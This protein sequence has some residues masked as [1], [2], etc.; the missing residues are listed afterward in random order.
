MI[1]ALAVLGKASMRVVTWLG[2]VVAA[3]AL[4]GCAG[5]T[6]IVQQWQDPAYAGG[7]F[8]RMFVIGVT[9]G[10]TVRRVFEDAFCAQLKARGV[11]CVQSY[12]L[13]PE[14][15]LAPRARYDEA[16]RAARADSV[17]IAGVLRVER[18]TEVVPASP[19][20]FGG[21]YSFYGAAW[22]GPLFMGYAAPPTV[23]QFDQ[24]FVESRLFSVASD[25]PVW[26]AAS[27]VFAPS[28]PQKDSEDFAR[29]M[30]EALAARKLL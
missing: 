29:V 17:F 18:R 22:G 15:G 25:R 5:P 19:V 3:A 8:K 24:V 6:R 11:E 14:D 13:V 16:V 28:N 21:A 2:L 23:F 7:P 20:V 27:E 9:H 4:A 26:T 12:T 1:G 30:I 10:S